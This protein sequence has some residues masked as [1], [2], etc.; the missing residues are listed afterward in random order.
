VGV[1]GR[2]HGSGRDVRVGFGVVLVNIV[3]FF[4]GAIPWS[5]NGI[6]PILFWVEWEI[7][8]SCR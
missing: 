3:G 8:K 1:S 2:V 7:A 6:P 4:G 5:E